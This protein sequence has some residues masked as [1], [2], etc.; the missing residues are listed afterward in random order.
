[1][2]RRPVRPNSELVERVLRLLED[3]GVPWSPRWLAIDGGDEVVSWIDG[4]AAGSGADVDLDAL[5]RMVRELHD[6]TATLGPGLLAGS[7]CVIH[8]DLQPR[9]VI[10]RDGHPVGLIDWEQARPGR[11]IEDVADLCWSFVE[12]VPG[13][14][15]AERG[16]RWRDVVDAYDLGDDSRPALVPTALARMVVCIDDI[17]RH[18]AAGSTRHQVLADRGDH[19][20]IRVMLDWTTAHR[21][22]LHHAILF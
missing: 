10:V 4:V 8:D 5:A 21:E 22:Q 17:E 12:P 19:L 20:G 6:L 16:R 1:M 11:R 15:P 18:A 2:P 14:D 3:A 13:S 7:E 9:N